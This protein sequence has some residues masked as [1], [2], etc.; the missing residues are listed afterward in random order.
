MRFSVRLTFSGKCN[1]PDTHSLEQKNIWNNKP[2]INEVVI[3]FKWIDQ[4]GR[5][6]YLCYRHKKMSEIS[7]C[8]I[9]LQPSIMKQFFL[10]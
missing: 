4:L 6:G 2:K 5:V 7:G 3:N 10:L 8:N 9:M 1:S